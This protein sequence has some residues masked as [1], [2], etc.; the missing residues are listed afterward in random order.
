MEN[1]FYNNVYASQKYQWNLLPSYKMGE[2]PTIQKS[3]VCKWMQ[4]RSM[5]KEP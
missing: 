1:K 4:L 2:K 5:L 3:G